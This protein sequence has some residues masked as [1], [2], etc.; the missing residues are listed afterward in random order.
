MWM[1]YY[2]YGLHTLRGGL[3]GPF[4]E[5]NL[6]LLVRDGRWTSDHKIRTKIQ[7]ARNAKVTF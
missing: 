7:T 2:T 4:K 3:H 6:L 1:A 5:P